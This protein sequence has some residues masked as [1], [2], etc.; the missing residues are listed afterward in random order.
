VYVCV[1]V[2]LCVCG[3]V[4]VG[5]C[6]WGGGEWVGVCVHMSVCVYVCVCARMTNIGYEVQGTQPWH[7]LV[8]TGHDPQFPTGGPFLVF[9]YYTF[10]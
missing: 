5:V 4:C 8:A 6:V 7:T 10:P 2:C 9:F 1:C 3:C